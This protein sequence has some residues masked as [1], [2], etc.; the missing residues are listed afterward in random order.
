MSDLEKKDYKQTLNLP[1]TSF[2]MKAKLNTKEPKMLQNWYEKNLQ[3][4]IKKEK[5]DAKKFI[6]HDGP[7]YANG[8]IHI[9]HALNKIL[10]DI[11]VKEKTLSGFDTSFTPGWDCHGLPIEM[12]VEK[13]TG[14]PGRKISHLEFRKKCQEYAKKQVQKQEEDF[15]RLGIFASWQDKYLTMNYA[16]QA[17]TIRAF[18]KIYENGYITKGEKPVYWCTDC[19][20]SLAEAEV[21]YINKDSHA[22]DVLYKVKE[23]D[24]FLAHFNFKDEKQIEIKEISLVVWTTTPWTLPASRAVSLNSDFAYCLLKTKKDEKE[25]YLVIQ[26]Q[27]IQETL[28]R[29]KIKDYEILASVNGALLDLL[30]LEHPFLEIDLPIIL[31]SHV[32]KGSGTGCVHTAPGHGQEDYIASLSYNLEIASPVLGNG[33]FKEDIEF[34]GSKHISTATDTIISVLKSKNNLLGYNKINHSYPHCWRHKS[35]IIFR[36]TPQWFI[37][38]SNSNLKDKA[39]QNSANVNWLPSWGK[40]RMQEMLENRPDWCISRQRTWGVPICFL[41]DKNTQEPHKDSLEI[42]EKV[43]KKVEEFGVEYWFSLDPKELITDSKNYIKTVDIL[44]VWFDSGVTHFSVLKKQEQLEPPADLYLEGN[45]QYRGWFQSSLLSSIA[46]FDK[47]PFKQVL[48]HGFTVDAKGKKMSKSLGNVISPQEVVNTLGADVLRLW[49][50]ASDFSDELN[51]SLDILKSTSDIYRKIRNTLR[52][53]LAN[54]FD[55]KQENLININELLDL[56]RWILF[57]TKELQLEV[58][59]D[60]KNYRFHKVVKKITYFCSNDLGAFYLDIIKDRQYT[61]HKKSFARLSCQSAIYHITQVLVRLISPILSFTGQEV[62]QLLEQKE[63]FVFLSSWY[64]E[65]D[66]ITLNKDFDA[67]FFQKAIA[68]KDEI[69][70]ELEQMRKDKIIGSSLQTKVNLYLDETTKKQLLLL[71]DEIKFLFLVSKITLLP[72]D[73]KPKKAKKTNLEY[74]FLNIEKLEK[75][76]CL[77]CWHYVDD[78]NSS[79]INPGICPRCVANIENQGEIR[80]HV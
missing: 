22:I 31:S 64:K 23:K 17:N 65:L 12:Q 5:Q 45:D 44:D 51:V 80:K 47:A 67:D 15:K 33:V 50:A 2:S 76:K 79:S 58:L 28:Q 14:K 18:A 62:W 59:E 71:K 60:Y 46:M 53:L 66:Q 69:N 32:T 73:K 21:E 19:A 38:I 6:L 63:E 55:F 74:L 54:N 3:E 9:G 30:L 20:S 7:P 11:I 16:Q 72:L 25:H 75:N 49:V 29:C 26:E 40:K 68:I 52:F 78:I 35:P 34:V 8:N 36:A 27:S 13:K 48:T 1:T 39:L 4:Q 24:D 77:R 57:K 61:C 43:A 56:D 37:N 41:L 42:F 70:K 10:K